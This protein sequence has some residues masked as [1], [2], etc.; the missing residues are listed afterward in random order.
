MDGSNQID[1]NTCHHNKKLFQILNHS[2]LFWDF[3][4]SLINEYSFKNLAEGCNK[5]ITSSKLPGG[6]RQTWLP[7]NEGKSTRLCKVAP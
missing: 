2:H 1:T 3:P 7:K 4:K 5:V 6:W